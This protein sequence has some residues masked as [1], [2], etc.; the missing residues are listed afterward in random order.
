LLEGVPWNAL[1]GVYATEKLPPRLDGIGRKIGATFPLDEVSSI[2]DF[3]ELSSVLQREECIRFEE[4][5][6]IK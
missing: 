1:L 3:L 2:V 4:G 5:R 6:Y